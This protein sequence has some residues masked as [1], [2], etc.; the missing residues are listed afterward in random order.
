MAL[1]ALCAQSPWGVTW[2]DVLQHRF[3]SD[4]PL[5]GHSVGNLLIAT[6]WE[7]LG[8]PVKGLELIGEL[9]G[10]E[11]RV[12]PMA[13]VPLEIEAEVSYPGWR[14]TK[15]V[16]GQSRV[17][18]TSGYVHNLR[19][20]PPDAP[21]SQEAVEAIE[22]AD[23]VIFGPGSWYTSVITHLLVPDLAQIGRAHV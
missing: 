13:A 21:A 17:A 6:L 8:D 7:L 1:A 9:L 10:A 16:R 23:W 22:Q 3:Q 15:T 20:S 12:L 14:Q 2:R 11:G 4:G 5:N 19:L 18:V